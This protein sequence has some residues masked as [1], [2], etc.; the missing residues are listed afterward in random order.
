MNRE[1]DLA[2]RLIADIARARDLYEQRV[3]SSLRG[4][5][6]FFHDE[7]VSTLANG[8]GRLIGYTTSKR[9]DASLKNLRDK[10]Q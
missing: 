1:H 5:W 10:Q 9:E 2:M 4:N 6:D 7:R 3:P 8:D